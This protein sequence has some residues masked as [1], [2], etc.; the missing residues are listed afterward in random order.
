M[1]KVFLIQYSVHPSLD[2]FQRQKELQ[3]KFSRF[4]VVSNIHCKSDT[5]LV[6][7]WDKVNN[8]TRMVYMCRY[9]YFQSKKMKCNRKLYSLKN[10]LKTTMEKKYRDSSKN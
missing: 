3:R 9:Q 4:L 6:I 10:E 8:Y 5:N 2:I 1:L 7:L